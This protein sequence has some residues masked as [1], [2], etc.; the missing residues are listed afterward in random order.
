MVNYSI[1]WNY[2]KNLFYVDF[3][4]FLFT[5][6]LNQIVRINTCLIRMTFIQSTYLLA[7]F[8]ISNI[9]WYMY[10]ILFTYQVWS[11][12]ELRFLKNSYN[13]SIQSPIRLLWFF[14]LFS[15]IILHEINFNLHFENVLNDDCITEDSKVFLYIQRKKLKCSRW[16]KAPYLNCRS[17]E[18]L[19]EI[20]KTAPEQSKHE[21]LDDNNAEQNDISKNCKQ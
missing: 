14:N 15:I 16:Q 20:K 8:T 18:W 4:I 1:N 19:L 10:K 11:Y 17:V 21:F 3:R 7:L 12:L 5:T 9:T 6:H 2:A 13:Q